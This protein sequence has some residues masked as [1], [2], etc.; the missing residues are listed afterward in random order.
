MGKKGMKAFLK[1]ATRSD[2]PTTADEASPADIEAPIASSSTSSTPVPS[3]AASK[4][5]PAE[6]AVQQAAAS[7]DSDTEGQEAGEESQGQ[8]TQRHKREALAL[9]KELQRSGKKSKDD[10]AKA[11][12]ALEDRQAQEVVVHGAR[13]KR[14]AAET[15]AALAVTVSALAVDEEKAERESRVADEIRQCGPSDGAVEEAAL[16]ELLRPLGLT[17]REIRADGHCLYRA[18]EH[19][20]HS[21]PSTAPTS[22]S[23]AAAA[24]AATGSPD[25]Q[26]TPAASGYQALRTMAANHIRANADGFLPY[27]DDSDA[28]Q[29]GKRREEGVSLLEQYCRDLE[30]TAVW[31][32]QLELGALA[33]ALQ[34]TITVYS[35]GLPP[36]TM[37]EEF[38]ES[39]GSSS[40]GSSPCSGPPLV[41]CYLRHAYGLGEH[42]NSVT[43]HVS[44]EDEEREEGGEQEEAENDVEGVN[45]IDG[46]RDRECEAEE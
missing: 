10:L 37:G 31:G 32:G 20:L 11:N 24:A 39:G 7:D 38:R 28:L 25:Q 9:K 13:G 16:R 41:V 45:G 36:V 34:R 33:Q 46:E 27:M 8:M 2:A 5:A 44:E 22:S 29:G 4:Q 18:L 43:T 23:A 26:P 40:G 30:G 6:S 42:Y 15:A 19:Q 12:R 3:T 35:V 17:L 14:L 21:H 1:S